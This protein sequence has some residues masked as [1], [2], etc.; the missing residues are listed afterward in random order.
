MCIYIYIAL[1]SARTSEG[2][3]LLLAVGRWLLP[4]AST[5][6]VAKQLGPA[7]ASSRCI[8]LWVW[9]ELVVDQKHLTTAS[10]ASL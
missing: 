1:I 2:W 3:T 5:C 7:W 4:T 8:L 9:P 6:P 10:C